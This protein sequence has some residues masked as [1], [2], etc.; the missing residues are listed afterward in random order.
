VQ[1]VVGLHSAVQLIARRLNSNPYKYIDINTG[2]MCIV[3]ETTKKEGGG[4]KST[5]N[6]RNY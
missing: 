5:M 2:K 4:D 1:Y 6:I 3:T